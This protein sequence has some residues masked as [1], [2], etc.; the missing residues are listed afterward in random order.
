MWLSLL[1]PLSLCTDCPHLFH[2]LCHHHHIE[3]EHLEVPCDSCGKNLRGLER[4]MKPIG[5]Q[6][7]VQLKFSCY[8]CGITVL[9]LGSLKCHFVVQH[10]LW[11]LLLCVFCLVSALNFFS[12]ELQSNLGLT[13][14]VLLVWFVRFV[15]LGLHLLHR[16]RAGL[17]WLLLVWI[18]KAFLNGNF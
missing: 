17:V 18:L 8:L 6:H 1:R 16:M 11:V 7:L 2:F 10:T 3:V 12:H 14:W 5:V 4:L 13:E 15:N 9:D